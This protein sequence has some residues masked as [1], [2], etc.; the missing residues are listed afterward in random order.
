MTFAIKLASGWICCSLS[1]H[2]YL[3]CISN[4][5]IASLWI[6][7]CP[8]MKAHC[9]QSN[10]NAAIKSLQ[11]STATFS[12]NVTLTSC[13]KFEFD[14]WQSWWQ[15]S[16]MAW[17]EAESRKS[18]KLSRHK[19]NE[20]IKYHHHQARVDQI[21]IEHKILIASSFNG[22]MLTCRCR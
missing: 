14:F 16:K 17:R 10:W 1:P 12:G 18:V 19:I 20:S 8:L 11:S 5:L 9:I 21:F 2:V 3:Q 7:D 6:I 15:R 4:C 22:S 13:N